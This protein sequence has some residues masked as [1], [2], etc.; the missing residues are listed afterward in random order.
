MTRVT[1]SK[2]SSY[3]HAR[4]GGVPA[5]VVDDDAEQRVPPVQLILDL[6][7]PNELQLQAAPFAV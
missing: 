5:G 3:L 4:R 7:A 6:A 1:K 2:A